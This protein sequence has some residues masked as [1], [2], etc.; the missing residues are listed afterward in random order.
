MVTAAAPFEQI[1][2]DIEAKIDNK[3]QDI[4]SSDPSWASRRGAKSYPSSLF[5]GILG[6]F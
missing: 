2:V 5:W 6:S 3:N 1:F 4:K